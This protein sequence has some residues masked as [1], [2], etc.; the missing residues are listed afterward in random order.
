MTK[1]II[2][3]IDPGFRSQFQITGYH[4]YGKKSVEGDYEKSACIVGAMRGNEYQQL[5]ASSLLIDKLTMLEEA[6]AISWNNEILVIPAVNSLSMNVGSR[7]WT[8]DN[9]DINRQFPGNPQGEPTS[10]IAASVMEAAK[11]YR[12]E[13][14]IPSSY[15]EGEFQPHIRMMHNGQKSASLA[16]LFGLPYVMIG[17][18]RSF[19]HK[20]LNYNWQEM[21]TESFSV[22]TSSTDKV[23]DRAARQA[24]SAVLRF[25]TRM[26]IIKYNCHNGYIASILNESELASI[27]SGNAGFFRPLAKVGDEVERGDLLAEIIDPYHGNVVSRIH[28]LSDGIIFYSTQKP[29]IMENSIVFKIIKKLHE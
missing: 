24:V 17:E 16:T 27:K 2:Y 1:E 13:I 20:T 11:G 15:L 21:G 26:G 6:G 18:K 12:Y 10:R 28:A 8:S 3:E 29:V 23:D 19:D 22:Y 9:S 7:Y 25:L 14:H 5:Y 4:F